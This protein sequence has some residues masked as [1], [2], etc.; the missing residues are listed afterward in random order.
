MADDRED[1]L[2]EKDKDKENFWKQILNEV[3][4]QSLRRL[5]PNKRVLVLGDDGC[6][7][8]SL[9]TR[10]RTPGDDELKKGAGLE[11]TYLNIHDEERDEHTRLSIWIQDGDKHYKDLLKYVVT[12]DTVKNVTIIICV[13]MA[14][15]WN[16][17]D[18]LENWCRILREHI[19][20]LQLS[21]KELNEME[22]GIVKEFQD[23]QKIDITDEEPKSARSNPGE[24]EEEPVL[25][26]GEN[27]L[28]DNLGIPV[29]VVAAKSDHM[30]VLE[31]EWEYREEHFDFLQKHL[32][33]FCLRCGAGLLYT[34]SKE[35]CNTSLL[36]KYLV[37]RIYGFSLTV[38]PQVIEKDA[39]F[40]PMGWDNEN[41]IKILDE[42]IKTFN[43]ADS[44]KD[45]ISKP[46][47]RKPISQEKEAVVVEDEQQF[48]EAQ[49]VIL[50]KAPSS[51]SSAQRP[52]QQAEHRSSQRTQMLSPGQ[53]TGQR[54]GIPSAKGK[55]DPTKTAAA[56][57]NSS[58]TVLANFFNSLLNKNSTKGV[59]GAP[60]NRSDVQAELEKM[61]KKPKE[62]K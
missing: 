36:Y 16:I 12:K 38:Q 57:Q 6:G 10:L 41:K 60:A 37:H 8:T 34:S 15:P 35:S 45:H 14:K 53:R 4:A 48:L 26:L 17:I 2:F 51:S 20:S 55:M 54:Q 13:D 18:S 22:R 23:F 7:K 31:K 50:N 42:H 44:F 9:I 61:S 30:S 49:L 21:A 3:S 46:I 27:V 56:A 1:N 19:H 47:S 58:E 29:V 32:R 24:E 39:I 5:A 33:N 40:I 25:P 59:K 62:E 11:Y 28:V 52:Q 43:S